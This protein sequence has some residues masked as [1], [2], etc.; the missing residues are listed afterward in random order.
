MGMP[1]GA[2]PATYRWPL[3][4]TSTTYLSGMP[5]M[6]E[7]VCLKFNLCGHD[8]DTFAQLYEDQTQARHVDAVSIDYDQQVCL[9]RPRHHGLDDEF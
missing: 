3:P 1:V 9:A 8:P 7:L 2:M 4:G 6:P 5:K